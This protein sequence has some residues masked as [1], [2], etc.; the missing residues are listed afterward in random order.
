MLPDAGWQAAA[1]TL[2]RALALT[3]LIVSTGALA[4]STRPITPASSGTSARCADV[5]TSDPV[6]ADVDQFW[7]LTAHEQAKFDLQHPWPCGEAA[8]D[9]RGGLL[10][11]IRFEDVVPRHWSESIFDRCNPEYGFH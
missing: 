3:C 2:L 4:Q 9:E 10:E 11:L 7:C 5:A 8:W 1:R 6:S